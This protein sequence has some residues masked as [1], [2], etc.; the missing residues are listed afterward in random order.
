MWAWHLRQSLTVFMMYPAGFWRMDPLPSARQ[1][2]SYGDC[3]E[4]KREYYQNCSVL[5]CV[6]VL[7]G[8]ADCVYHVG[9]L[10]PCMVEWCWWDSSLIWKANWFPSVL[11]H[12]W[13]G[14][15]TCKNCPN[16][17]Y[18]VL[19]LYTATISGEWTA[20]QS[21]QDQSSIARHSSPAR[22][23]FD[24]IGNVNVVGAMVPFCADMRLLDVTRCNSYHTSPKWSASPQRT[25]NLHATYDAV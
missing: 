6:T 20:V 2:P 5:G 8:P 18:N 22:E 13:F 11:W 12:C 14:H 17:T 4:V 23:V 1:H 19:C 15:M 24:I 3:L 10:T 9:T 7:T 16:V 25:C 21:I